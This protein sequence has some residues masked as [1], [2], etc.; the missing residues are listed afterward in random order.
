MVQRPDGTA[1]SSG[2]A[3]PLSEAKLCATKTPLIPRATSTTTTPFEGFPSFPFSLFEF[4]LWNYG[5]SWTMTVNVDLVTAFHG[6]LCF[7]A[8]DEITLADKD[9]DEVVQSRK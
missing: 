5:S 2:V 3:L 8:A 7:E 9:A 6:A 4:K 1:P